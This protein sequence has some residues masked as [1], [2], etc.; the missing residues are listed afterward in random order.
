MIRYL[1]I[2]V[3]QVMCVCVRGQSSYFRCHGPGEVLNDDDDDDDDDK[4]L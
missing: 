4:R 2:L 1:L 3:S